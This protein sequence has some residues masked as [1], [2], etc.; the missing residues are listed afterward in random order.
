MDVSTTVSS[1]KRTVRTGERLVKRTS[2]PVWRYGFN[3]GPTRDFR[4]RPPALGAE[5]RR[6]L[7]DV[8]RDGLAVSNLADLTGDPTLLE[9]LQEQAYALEAQ[10]EQELDGRR[11]RIATGVVGGPK[12]KEFVMELLDS[13]RPVIDPKGLLA[14][15]AL[16]E[17]LRGIA[18]GYYGLRTRVSD[19][20]F[21]R[22]LPTPLPP[23]SSQLWHRDLPEDYFILKMFVYLEDCGETNGPFTYLVGTHGKGDRKF[24]LPATDDGQTHAQ[25]RRRA[26]RCRRSRPRAAQHRRGRFAWCSR[27]PSA[28]TRAAGSRRRDVCSSTCCTRRRQRCPTACSASLR[29]S[30]PR[31]GRATWCSTAAPRATRSSRSRPASAELLLASQ[32]ALVALVRRGR[33]AVHGRVSASP[34]VR[35]AAQAATERIGRSDGS[36]GKQAK[37]LVG[38]RNLTLCNLKSTLRTVIARPGRGSPDEPTARSPGGGEFMSRVGAGWALRWGTV[39]VVVGVALSGLVGSHVCAGGWEL[40]APGQLVGGPLRRGSTGRDNGLGEHVRLHVA[41]HR[42]AQVGVLRR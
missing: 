13:R 32:S 21:W 25:Q 37:T 24:Q 29:A 31:T 10:R 28:T 15:T 36:P 17:Q 40:R 38:H 42:G 3:A 12:D 19:I 8:D 33:F 30:D 34:C 7:A 4:K 23:R 22:N 11:E 35:R 20:N 2:E 27:T 41:G 39:A 1:V 6:V 14:Q 18:D 26:R 16:H 9:R 5:A